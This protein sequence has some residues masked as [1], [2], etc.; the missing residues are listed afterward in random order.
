[1]RGLD[2]PEQLAWRLDPAWDRAS[3][4][5]A[6]EG[7]G[8]AVK[9]IRQAVSQ[10]RKIVV[11]G[12]YDV[13]GVTAT[14][15]MVRVLERLGVKAGFFIPNRFSDGYGLNLDCIR[16]LK[17]SA[18]PSLIVSVDC[19]IRSV[20]EVEASQEM[21]IDW[22]ITDHHALGPNLPPALAVVHP[23]LG[24][25]SNP[26][27]SGVGVAFKLAQ[28][29]LEAELSVVEGLSFLDG[30]LKLVAIGTIADMVPLLGE[31]A[32]LVR[33]GLL[34]LGGNNGPGLRALLAGAK[35]GLNIG[36]A[37]IA[38]GIGPR[39]NAVGRMGGAE[40]AVRLLLTR[41]SG[42][43]ATLMERVERLNA[44]RKTVQQELLKNLPPPSLEGFD[45]VVE[46]SAHKGV[47]GIV[48]GQ[49]VRESGR[50]AGVCTVLDGVAQCS[51]RAPE[52]YDL[53][54]LLDLARP[55]LLSGGGHRL[56]AGMSFDLSKVDFVRRSMARGAEAQ[57]AHQTGPETLIDG[58]DTRE[59]PEKS[60]LDALE[61]WGQGCPWPLV[62][63]AGRLSRTPE[64]FGEKHA[65]LRIQGVPEP[66][67][68]FSAGDLSS[69]Y[70]E[71]QPLTFAAAPQDHPRWGRSW[72]VE[73]QLEAT[74]VPGS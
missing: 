71:G 34:A 74:M 14:A 66:L 9:V 52:G 35:V 51:L 15:L 70:A 45:L 27:L 20:A 37:D 50:P 55:Y 67:N 46:A 73:A 60:H 33:R 7:V 12:D 32:L 22:V 57:M 40:D 25:Y 62:A 26:H 54:A 36:A 41:D 43:A 47:I 39:L 28:A 10:G 38:F 5:Y 59:I 18:D 53:G 69:R 49:R 72:V 2:T 4:P 64:T 63:I 17:A 16:D 8:A 29:L 23:A 30:L 11:Y 48:A 1:L 68:W 42:E 24:G 31:N 19:G 21:G 13:D 58:F 6:L 61:P 56:A 65:R 3:D 44:E